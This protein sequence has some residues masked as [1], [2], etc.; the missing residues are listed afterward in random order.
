MWEVVGETVPLALGVALSPL[1]IMA[2]LLLL[3]SPRG[4]TSS[5][6]FALGR[7]LG[8]LVSVG[9][10]V[11]LSER[12][13]NSSSGSTGL[14]SVRVVAGAALVVLGLKKIL[15]QRAREGEPKLPGWMASVQDMSPARAFGVAVLLSLTNPKE[16]L[17]NLS[18]GVTVGG[19]DVSSG[20]SISVMVVYTVLGCLTVL[21]PVLANVAAKERMRSPLASMQHWLER[22][23]ALVMGVVLIVL[24]ALVVSGGLADLA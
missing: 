3:T 19:A 8:V 4:G 9:I 2:V 22:N 12:L 10:F 1:P 23:N 21:I 16:I 18:A 14:A 13:D 24:G 15:G 20:S 6:M 11:L 7:V 17:F 5:V